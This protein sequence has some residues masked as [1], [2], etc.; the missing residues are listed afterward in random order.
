M[1]V[2]TRKTIES[3]REVGV[4]SSLSKTFN[5]FDLILL[6]LGAII[7]TGVFALTGIIAAN[8]SGP[9]VTVSYGIAGVTCIFVALAYTELATMLPASGSIYTYSYVAFGELFAWLIGSVIILE[10][11][12]AA[13]AVAAS[14][15]SYVQRLLKSAGVIIPIEI[16][17]VPADGGVLN[18]L[19]LFITLFIGFILYLGTKD[20]KRLNSILVTIKMLAILAFSVFAAP[21]FNVN[22][23]EDFIPFGFDNVLVGSSILFFAFTGFGTLASAAEECRNPKRDLT[24]GIIGSLVLSTVIYIIVSGLLTGI[25]SFKE[26]NNTEALAHALAANNSNVGSA[27]VAAGAVCGMATV[28][29]MNIYGTS[30]IFYVISRDGLLPKSFAKL[31]N[32]YST[33]YITIILFTVITAVLGSFFPPKILAQLSSMGSIIDYVTVISIVILFRFR[34]PDTSRPFKCPALF[35]IAPIALIACSYLLF[36][37]ILDSNGTLLIT[38]KIIIIWFVV[39]FILYLVRFYFKRH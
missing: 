15:S 36:K 29:M 37:Q 17:A 22:N 2:F 31:H 12:F 21:H 34:Y 4:N 35:V 25:I 11:G 18:L 38:G 6:G 28:L 33:P 32:K 20:S 9:A 23:W 30:R 10:L 1:G 26:L 5:A 16:T 24:I 19:A 13:G 7:G 8:Y 39:M 27:L 3:V 14:W